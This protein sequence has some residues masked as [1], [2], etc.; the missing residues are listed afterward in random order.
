MCV[1]VCAWDSVFSVRAVDCEAMV[2]K[3]R[4]YVA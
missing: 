2:A 1:R 3:W 4:P